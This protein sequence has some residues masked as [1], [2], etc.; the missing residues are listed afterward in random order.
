MQLL[1]LL[2]LLLYVLLIF[3]QLFHLFFP[4]PGK[5][6]FCK[7]LFLSSSDTS[8]RFFCSFTSCS[9]LDLI[10]SLDFSSSSSNSSTVRWVHF[11][12]AVRL[13]FDPLIPSLSNTS[14]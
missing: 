13:D 12:V 2:K 8:I 11:C 6:F 7:S 1:C 10:C 9:R 4:L 3:Q 14:K 5:V